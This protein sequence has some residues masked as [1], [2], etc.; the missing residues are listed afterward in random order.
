MKIVIKFLFVFVIL[1]IWACDESEPDCTSFLGDAGALVL[2]ASH[3]GWKDNE[4]IE[5]HTEGNDKGAPIPPNDVPIPECAAC[6]GANGACARPM[7]TWHPVESC[8]AYNCHGANHGYTEISDCGKCHFA[9]AGV[10]QC[11]VYH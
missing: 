3:P 9:S 10:F 1:F 5:C 7:V 6:H 4:C 2:E 11:T 8:A